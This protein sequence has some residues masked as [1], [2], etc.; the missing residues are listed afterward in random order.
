L[1]TVPTKW[2]TCTV[3]TMIPLVQT[4]IQVLDEEE[5]RMRLANLPIRV[6]FIVEIEHHGVC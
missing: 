2:G 3:G 1:C 4:T 6:S 5:W